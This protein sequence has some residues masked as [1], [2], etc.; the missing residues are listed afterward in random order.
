MPG[1]VLVVEDDGHGSGPWCGIARG[2]LD[3]DIDLEATHRLRAE[4]GLPDPWPTD[5]KFLP[6]R[7]VCKT[8]DKA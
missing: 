5:R 8:T 2:G 6:V 7:L 1:D 3:V 4:R